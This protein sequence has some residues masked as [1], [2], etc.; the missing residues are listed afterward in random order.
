MKPLPKTEVNRKTF[1]TE[2]QSSQS[3]EYFLIKNS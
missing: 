3:S 1:T 2:T